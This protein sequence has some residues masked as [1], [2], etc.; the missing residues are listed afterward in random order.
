MKKIRIFLIEDNRILRDGLQ[1][2]AESQ[3][4][5]TLAGTAC[6]GD[7][8]ILPAVRKSKAQVVLIGS[9]SRE[10]NG[11][12]LLHLL[13]H[14]M[15]ELK[16]IGIGLAEEG[17]E[18]AG[19]V[20]AGASGIIMKDAGSDD[21]LETIRWVAREEKVI[22]PILS[23]QFFPSHDVPGAGTVDDELELSAAPLTK[24]EQEIVQL[25]ADSSSNKEIARRLNIAIFTVKS[26]VHNIL[27]RLGLHSRLQIAR[28][29]LGVKSPVM[30]AAL[31]PLQN[32]LSLHDM[33]RMRKNA[34]ASRTALPLRPRQKKYAL[35]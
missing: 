11:P 23:A 24:R 31:P 21:V 30:N 8:N 12:E 22:L 19:F 29:A 13:K 20:K 17:E 7:E 33:Q 27:V 10:K 26:H 25:I 32:I 2:L 34:D 18:I 28:Y 6:S 15:P 5:M 3:S 35:M 14:A 9:G 16:L 1:K 4:D